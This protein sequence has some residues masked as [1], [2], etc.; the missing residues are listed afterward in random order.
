MKVTFFCLLVTTFCGAASF[1]PR[2]SGPG[3]GQVDGKTKC[4]EG[5]TTMTYEIFECNEAHASNN[6]G[7]EYS[8]PQARIVEF[9]GT[10]NKDILSPVDEQLTVWKHDDC[11]CDCYYFSGGL[12]DVYGS[13]P[14]T[15][16]DERETEPM[17]V[18]KQVCK[19]PPT[20]PGV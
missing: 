5:C 8:S 11:E 20:P 19:K 18:Q 3:P 15:C 9:P 13:G 14:G 12:G 7:H 16:A 4:K 10:G 6:Q 1:M 2:Q 17:C